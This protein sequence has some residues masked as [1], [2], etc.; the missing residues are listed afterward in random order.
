MR[1]N[2][3]KY[4]F[5]FIFVIGSNPMGG[6]NK[7]KFHKS[8]VPCSTISANINKIFPFSS[9]KLLVNYLFCV[10]LF[11]VGMVCYY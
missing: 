3:P 8:G 4:T 2:Y 10:K 1:N 6:G 11:S 7:I 9:T 5:C